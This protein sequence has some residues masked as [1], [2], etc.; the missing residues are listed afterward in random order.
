MEV[1][2][3][4]SALKIGALAITFIAL[5]AAA[6]VMLDMLGIYLKCI[7]WKKQK[8]PRPRKPRKKKQDAIMQP[9]TSGVQD[10]AL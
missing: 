4:K 1:T 2:E 8:K 5:F 10:T 9:S 6:A 7:K 3:A